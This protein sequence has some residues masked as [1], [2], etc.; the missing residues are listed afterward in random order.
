MI[1]DPSD[2]GAFPQGDPPIVPA[3]HPDTPPRTSL[4]N[5]LVLMPLAFAVT[6]VIGAV[7][8]YVQRD[9]WPRGDISRYN[10]L[11]IQLGMTDAEV[12]EILGLPPGI[13]RKR[14]PVGGI[15]SAGNWGLI[16]AEDGLPKRE[17]NEMLGL[18]GAVRY[19]QWWGTY[20][21]IGI[22]IDA[23]GSVVGKYLIEI[24]W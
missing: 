1:S 12:E 17:L 13:H 23:N 24:P 14:R 11:Q 4:R 3:R 21:A 10:Y 5:R 20:H 9:H 15:T 22:A 16:I 2:D 18:R 6:G 7:V 19:Q 8:Y